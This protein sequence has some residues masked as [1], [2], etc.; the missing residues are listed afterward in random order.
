MQQ[1]SPCG[2]V[3]DL[4]KAFN[5][6]CR[7]FLRAL[8][9]RLGFPPG[10]INA[11]FASMKGLCRQALVA[12]A[13]H[14]SAVSTTGIPEGDPLSILGMFSLCC[15]FRA[16]VGQQDSLAVPFSYADN[17]EVVSGDVRSLT[18]IIHALDR[19]SSVCMLPV[20][21]SKCWTWAFC[22]ADR[23]ILR[24][25]KLAGQLVPVKLAPTG[26]L[27][28]HVM[29]GSPVGTSVFSGCVDFLPL[30]FGNVGSSLAVFTHMPC[31][32]VR[33]LGSLLPPLPG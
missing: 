26:P 17:W 15:L 31:M 32:H 20:A 4:I 6:V 14:G 27:L 9:L 29:V 30:G 8:M 3:L 5:V 10:V 1:V 22:T 11:W 33:Q 2:V 12:G 21:P 13:V 18:G 24:E 28:L 16:V 25:V 23:K 19:M 7:A